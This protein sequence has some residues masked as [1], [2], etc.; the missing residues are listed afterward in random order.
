MGTCHMQHGIE[1]PGLGA[2]K[3]V[4]TVETVKPVQQVKTVQ[5]VKPVQSA[6]TVDVRAVTVINLGNGL[7]KIG[8][9]ICIYM[10]NGMYHGSTGKIYNIFKPSDGSIG[11]VASEL[12]ENQSSHENVFKDARKGTKAT[13]RIEVG[14]KFDNDAKTFE[15]NMISRSNGKMK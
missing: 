2:D 8:E 15:Q 13:D 1:I 12:T 3:P 10:G 7:M 11:Y 5:Q 6:R 14:R 4:E 9:D